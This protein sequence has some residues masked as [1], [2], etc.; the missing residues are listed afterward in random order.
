MIDLTPSPATFAAGDLYNAYKIRTEANIRL[1]LNPPVNP[2]LFQTEFGTNK[3]LIYQRQKLPSKRT[4]YR[5]AVIRILVQSSG[6]R[7]ELSRAR[8]RE[9]E[10][11]PLNQIDTPQFSQQKLDHVQQK[12]CIVGTIHCGKREKSLRSLVFIECE[13]WTSVSGVL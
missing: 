7:S 5:F 1:H 2:K 11:Q 3:G 6:M 8:V 4:V 13:V 9:R 10:Q 12:S